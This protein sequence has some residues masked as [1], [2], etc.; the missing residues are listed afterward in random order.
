MYVNSTDYVKFPL[1]AEDF[2]SSKIIFFMFILDSEN[3]NG[4]NLWRTAFLCDSQG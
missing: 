3:N 2:T 1:S 4:K